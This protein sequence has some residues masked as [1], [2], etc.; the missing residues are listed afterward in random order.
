MEEQNQTKQNL[1]K[2]SQI[3]QE[4]KPVPHE[5]VNKSNKKKLIWL[6]MFILLLISGFISDWELII[7]AG[8]IAGPS[9][10]GM[11]LTVYVFVALVSI[12]QLKRGK[13]FWKGLLQGII[14]FAILL[15]LLTVIMNIIESRKPAIDWKKVEL[16]PEDDFSSPTNKL[17][18]KN[19]QLKIS[20]IEFRFSTQSIQGIVSVGD[21]YIVDLERKTRETKDKTLSDYKSLIQTNG[22][23]DLDDRYNNEAD[24]S[25]FYSINL[26][27]GTKSFKRVMCVSD[28]NTCPQAMRDIIDKIENDMG[29]DIFLENN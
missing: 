21:G 20:Q 28:Y 7:D 12:I 11:L 22:F 25:Q 5:E 27:Y 2:E 1:E 10:L 26:Y 16:N 15:G 18:D 3:E 17:L 29:E 6:V 24:D 23:L 14:I 8:I 9:I 4:Y 13:S 19:D